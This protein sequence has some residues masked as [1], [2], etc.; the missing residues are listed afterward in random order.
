MNIKKVGV[1]GCGVMGGG[2]V[3]LCAQSGYQVTVSEVNTELLNNGLAAIN[4]SLTRGIEKGKITQA[5]RDA[6]LARIKGTINLPDL[7]DCDLVIEAI[8]EVL[9]LKKKVFAELD[10]IC[11]PDTILT[12]NTS[13]L[14]IIDM[15]AATRRADK[16]AGMHFFNPVMVMKLLELIRTVAT[17][18]ETVATIKEFGKSVGKT[19]VVS[20]DFPGFLT[21]RLGIVQG[22]EAIRMVEGGVGTAED[23]DTAMKL[24][25]GLP[26]GPL[27]LTDLVGLDVRLD[28]AQYLYE[29]TK[30]PKFAPPV[31]M[32][33]MVV[34]GW[35]GR[36]TGRGFYTYEKK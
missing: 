14:S 6:A 3:Q 36:K 4:S 24:G 9:D 30:D 1:I 12:S 2:I 17:G 29:M 35:L 33:K 34:A 26:M 32:Q 13:S 23:I 16:V 31:L 8:I 28:V 27:E 10:K 5:D 25:Y 22:L 15:A 18:D 11:P 19:V 7:K 20:K 21:S